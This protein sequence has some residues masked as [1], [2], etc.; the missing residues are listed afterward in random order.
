MRRHHP[1][2]VCTPPNRTYMTGIADGLRTMCACVS[3]LSGLY[4][5]ACFSVSRGRGLK[6]APT[7]N[8]EICRPHAKRLYYRNVEV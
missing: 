4:D 5:W 6:V 8:G 3:R 7:G 2:E 1:Q